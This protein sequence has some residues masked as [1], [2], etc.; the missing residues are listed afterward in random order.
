MDS[1]PIT[2]H[3]AANAKMDK[4]VAFF[5]ARNAAGYAPSGLP[6][7][8]QA[9]QN[10]GM[11]I[12]TGPAAAKAPLKNNPRGRVSMGNDAEHVDTSPKAPQSPVTPKRRN[13]SKQSASVPSKVRKSAS[14]SSME[15]DEEEE[16][17][18]EEMD[19]VQEETSPKR[20]P[21]A[22]QMEVDEED[23]LDAP[24]TK[25]KRS[26]DSM[27]PLSGDGIR[28]KP[29]R[30]LIATKRTGSAASM[31]AKNDHIEEEVDTPKR[32]GKSRSRDRI[33]SPKNRSPGSPHSDSVAASHSAKSLL[34]VEEN[35][36]DSAAGSKPAKKK[37]KRREILTPTPLVSESAPAAAPWPASPSAQGSAQKPPGGLWNGFISRTIQKMKRMVNTPTKGDSI[38]TP[39]HQ[40]HHNNQLES[41]SEPNGDI[42]PIETQSDD[43]VSSPNYRA[44]SSSAPHGMGSP[45]ALAAQYASPSASGHVAGPAYVRTGDGFQRTPIDF[46]RSSSTED[47]IKGGYPSDF[48]ADARSQSAGPMNSPVRL[49]APPRP[50]N[51]PTAY[52]ASAYGPSS[53]DWSVQHSRSPMR[54]TRDRTE[55]WA[56]VSSPP[57]APLHQTHHH[58]QQYPHP[59]N[60]HSHAPSHDPP[61]SPPFPHPPHQQPIQTQVPS[62]HARRNSLDLERRQQKK[63]SLFEEIKKALRSFLFAVTVVSL[64]ILVIW[65]FTGDMLPRIFSSDPERLNRMCANNLKEVF[66]RRRGEYD[67][68][69][70][71]APS[72]SESE[73]KLLISSVC[74]YEHQGM[75]YKAVRDLLLGDWEI[76]PTKDGSHFYTGP[77][78]IK[79]WLCAI[80]DGAAD[81]VKDNVLYITLICSVLALFMYIF[82][83]FRRFR[84][85]KALAKQISE[86]I[87]AKLKEEFMAA[88]ADSFLI[89]DYMEDDYG[90]SVAQKRVWPQVV[91]LVESNIRVRTLPKMVHGD[92]LNVW[93]W[94]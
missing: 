71:D 6:P 7:A 23:E 24:K 34:R 62:R 37:P 2:R 49:A 53:S 80:R 10:E 82:Y 14:K 21:K 67:C 58:Q 47:H 39:G 20:S 69:E 30:R 70:R 87:I 16:N 3:G 35:D 43:F 46:R 65:L 52:L 64:L 60:T 92:Q 9:K 74:P 25:R 31:D 90:K 4:R 26:R 41:Y 18:Q 83:R 72:V 93:V 63:P 32:S 85:D 77:T 11:V 33:T 28:K 86:E 5:G 76:T 78:P 13:S 22:N 8:A 40:M 56:N 36:D 59:H 38:L 73:L 29:S 12:Y 19:I 42:A 57:P 17:P 75:S 50:T 15:V 48:I 79:P 91:D 66:R 68:G 54:V 89:K 84:S 55:N 45:I 88:G 81:F 51:S 94:S 61:T 27:T 1:K 44:S